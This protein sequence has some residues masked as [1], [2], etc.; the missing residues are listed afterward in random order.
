MKKKKQKNLLTPRQI[1]LIVLFFVLALAGYTY[2]IFFKPIAPDYNYTA[3]SVASAAQN[4]DSPE[5]EELIKSGKAVRIKLSGCPNLCK[6]SDTLYRGAQPTREGFENLK[7]LGIKTVISLRDHHSDEELLAGTELNYIPLSSDTWEVTPDRIA[8]F[9]QVATTPDAAPVF[10]HCLHGA[11]RTGTMVA[12]YRIVVQ[13]W[14]KNRAIREMTHGGFGYHPIWME[15]PN[16]LRSLDVEALK[17]QI[18]QD[19]K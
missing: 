9:L 17:T 16:I 7:K 3:V 10:V 2:F 8:D 15:L 12:S 5:V 18:G 4:P 14:E 13:N 1:V 19:Q 11:D 6:V